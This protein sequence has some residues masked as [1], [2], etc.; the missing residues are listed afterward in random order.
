MGDIW[1]GT[2]DGDILV[3][4]P[5]IQ[6]RGAPHV[7]IWSRQTKSIEKYDPSILR[8]HI[9]RLT[10][11]IQWQ[12]HYRNY[13]DWKVSNT[14]DLDEWQ[15]KQQSYYIEHSNIEQ[16]IEKRHR[17]RIEELGLTYAGTRRVSEKRVR[18]MANCYLCK[19]SLD[20]EIDL[21]CEACGWILCGCG[22]CGCGFG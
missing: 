11:K 3:Y 17:M 19:K 18:R 4:D 14:G 2:V 10:D 12:D 16:G 20:N 8:K 1:I 21:E 22:A 7:F 15:R 9:R 5:S 6:I 13:I